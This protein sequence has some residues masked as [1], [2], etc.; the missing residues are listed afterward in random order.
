MTATN[1][2][3]N[4]GGFRCSLPALTSSSGICNPVWAFT[5]VFINKA[6]VRVF[7]FQ[8]SLVSALKILWDV[9]YELL[10]LEYHQGCRSDK[11]PASDFSY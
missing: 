3:S 6:C 1:M 10:G 5:K 2:C 7:T 9:K 4:F 8:S 11:S